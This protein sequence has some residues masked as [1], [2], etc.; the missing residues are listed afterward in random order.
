[1]GSHNPDQVAVLMDVE[2]YCGKCHKRGT[3]RLV[4]YYSGEVIMRCNAC[5]KAGDFTPDNS[6]YNDPRKFVPFMS[7]DDQD[8][9]ENNMRHTKGRR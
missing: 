2:G 5:K 4:A 6:T 3:A 8:G 1:M 7:D 9:S